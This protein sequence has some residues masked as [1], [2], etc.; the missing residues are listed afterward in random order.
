MLLV[1]IWFEN[2]LLAFP[3]VPSL[4]L[5]DIA[6][7]VPPIASG[8]SAGRLPGDKELWFYKSTGM[9]QSHE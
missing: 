3:R 9:G 7:S 6:G 5:R 2:L 8:M 4:V 1:L